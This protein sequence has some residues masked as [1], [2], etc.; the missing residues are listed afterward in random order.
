M[1]F[2]SIACAFDFGSW[3]V[4]SILVASFFCLTGQNIEDV[5]TMKL[6]C[7]VCVG[8]NWCRL[9]HG[10]VEKD[11]RN[12]LKHDLIPSHNNKHWSVSISVMF[13]S[14]ALLS[15]WRSFIS[16][17]LHHVGFPVNNAW[18]I[19]VINSFFFFLFIFN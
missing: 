6:K 16:I 12:G 9:P 17:R 2:A 11:E 15:L 3:T 5:D 1:T 10:A 4:C 7:C 19:V 13:E 18:V 14:I 8:F